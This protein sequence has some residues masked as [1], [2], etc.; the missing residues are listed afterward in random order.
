MTTRPSGAGGGGRQPVAASAAYST[1]AVAQK[2]LGSD[3]NAPMLVH[4]TDSAFQGMPFDAVNYFG[5]EFQTPYVA[6]GLVAVP[7][8]SV[9]VAAG[10]VLDVTQIRFF[11]YYLDVTL[12]PV[13][14]RDETLIDGNNFLTVLVNGKSPWDLTAAFTYTNPLPP[15]ATLTTRR[16]GFRWLNRNL[17]SD[18]GA[19]DVHLI[20]PENQSLGLVV[21]VSLVV[22]VGP[23]LGLAYV[24]ATVHGRWLSMQTWKRIKE[25][26]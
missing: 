17:L 18:W 10:Q 26:V 13:L 7:L 24:G 3:P 1:A 19:T 21:T 6:P 25:R 11:A 16:A 20:V 5:W 23:G 9:Q 12:Q 15:P 22:P 4:I 8:A 14:Y 2:P